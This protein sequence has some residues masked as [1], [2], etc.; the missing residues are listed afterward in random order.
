M[1]LG[2]TSTTETRAPSPAVEALVY[3][4]ARRAGGLVLVLGCLALW[5]ALVTWSVNDPSLTHA[6]SGTPRNLMGPVGAIVSDLLLQMLGLGAVISIAIPIVWGLQLTAQE[7]LP[8][9]E[10]KLLLFVFGLLALAGGLSGL[11]RSGNWPLAHG[12]GG[13]LGDCVLMFGAGAVA[14]VSS[15]LATFIAGLVLLASGC[16]ALAEAIG[17]NGRDLRLAWTFEDGGRRRSADGAP[18][19]AVKPAKASRASFE[20][21]EASAPSSPVIRFPTVAEPFDDDPQEVAP[22]VKRRLSLTP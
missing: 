7:R 6:T 8:R 10:L 11:P 19:A 1:P 14:L 3:G 20:S 17:L 15:T 22:A 12:Y 5:L 4:W 9:I 21:A 18:V 2:S 13:F 16:W